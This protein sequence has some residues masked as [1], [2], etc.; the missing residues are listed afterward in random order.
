MR[1]SILVYDDNEKTR[2]IFEQTLHS[3]ANL[4]KIN[5]EQQIISYFDFIS[6]LDIRLQNR[7]F[8]DLVKERVHEKLTKKK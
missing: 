6:W 2:K 4:T 3:L 1:K 7:K 8:S 5:A